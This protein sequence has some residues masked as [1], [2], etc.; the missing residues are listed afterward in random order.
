MIADRRFHQHQISDC[1]FSKSKCIRCLRSTHN[2]AD[3]T[4]SCKVNFEKGVC[5][6]CGLP[7]SIGTTEVHK[8]AFGKACGHPLQD[9]LFPLAFYIFGDD[10]LRIQL[11]ARFER[12]WDSDEQFAK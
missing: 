4:R 12:K 6:G 10:R 1:R 2:V 9:R 7:K 8:Q 11:E 5:F 3:G